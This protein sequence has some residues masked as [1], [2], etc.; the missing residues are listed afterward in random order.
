MKKK[1]NICVAL[2]GMA[3]RDASLLAYSLQGIVWG[4]KF[5]DLLFAAGS[6]AVIPHFS[7]FGRVFADVKAHDIPN[8]V[9]NTVRRMVEQGASVVTVH[10]SGGKAMLEAA[11]EAAR[12]SNCIVAAVTVLTS[13]DDT[14][15]L[16]VFKEPRRTAFRELA[17]A[18][19]EARVNAVVCS[20][21]DLPLVPVELA[22]IVPGIRVGA[23]VANDDQKAVARAV[24]ACNIIVVGRPITQASDPVAAAKAIAQAVEG[25]SA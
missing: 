3:F 1:P 17:L 22:T 15:C 20:A 11:V 25:A 14:D 4:F 6:D 9:A 19:A 21:E 5:N 10:A 12:G 23:N 2:D 16:A 8:T 13:L 7:R 24:P 18:A